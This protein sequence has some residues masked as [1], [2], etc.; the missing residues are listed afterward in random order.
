MSK[1]LNTEHSPKE[2]M[3]EA[4][5]LGLVVVDCFKCIGS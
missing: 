2:H 4:S 5:N 1:K 3:I